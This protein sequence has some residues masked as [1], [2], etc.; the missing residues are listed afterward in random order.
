MVHKIV[1]KN[2]W[3]RYIQG[4]FVSICLLATPCYAGMYFGNLDVVTDKAMSPINPIPFFAN[5]QSALRFANQ[6]IWGHD[7]AYIEKTRRYLGKYIRF[8]RDWAHLEDGH[9][10][11][12]RRRAQILMGQ[13]EYGELALATIMNY[14]RKADKAM[15]GDK[16]ELPYFESYQLLYEW[17]HQDRWDEDV[18]KQIDIVK[19][20]FIVKPHLTKEELRMSKARSQLWYSYNESVKI[21]K[22][23]QVGAEVYSYAIPVSMLRR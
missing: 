16:P 21:L 15:I 23:Y 6:A 13:V 8:Q 5:K 10:E 4:A 18:R 12:D 20:F 14:L 7:R 19:H 22:Q 3:N 17:I 2:A 1:S 11:R 9:T